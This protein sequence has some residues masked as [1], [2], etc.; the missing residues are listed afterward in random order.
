MEQPFGME[1]PLR[2]IATR[3]PVLSA[4]DICRF[5][6]GETEI[7][8]KMMPNM[9][10][11]EVVP[12]AFQLF[13]CGCIIRQHHECG[14]ICQGC[15]KELEEQQDELFPGEH[16]TPVQLDWL[17]TPCRQHYLICQYPFCAMGGCVKHL[18][19]GPDDRYYCKDHFKVVSGEFELAEVAERHGLIAAQMKGF[20]R[21]LFFDR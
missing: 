11:T 9:I 19:L 21:S 6:F 8:K 18:A 3:V 2:V 16:L 4:K 13:P 1:Q 10:A 17:A 7:T 20:W 5:G 12:R 15:R 14:A